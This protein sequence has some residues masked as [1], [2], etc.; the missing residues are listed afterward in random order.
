MAEQESALDRRSHSVRE[1]MSEEFAPV[2]WNGNRR[3]SVGLRSTNVMGCI[4][5]D[6]EL[7][8]YGWLSSWG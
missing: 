3:A 4:E 8:G 2:L 6:T 7:P 5:F 1:L